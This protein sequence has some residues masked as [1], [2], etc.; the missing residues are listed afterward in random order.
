MKL[1]QDDRVVP[2]KHQE[3][4]PHREEK[5]KIIQLIVR[6]CGYSR[7]DMKITIVTHRGYASA[8]LECC[9]FSVL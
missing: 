1:E 5:S 9:N 6:P 7:S 2:G 3:R 8:F 4:F